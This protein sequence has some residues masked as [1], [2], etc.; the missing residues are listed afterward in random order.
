MSNF[1]KQWNNTCKAVGIVSIGR[2]YA[3]QLLAVIYIIGGEREIF[4]HNKKLKADLDYIQDVYGFKEGR[5]PDDK[6]AKPF[7]FFQNE[8]EEYYTEHKSYPKWVINLM[9][10][11]YNIN[12]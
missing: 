2:L 8:I 11:N 5:I 4:T 6:V 3:A 1:R 10:D 12:L 9:K 7:R